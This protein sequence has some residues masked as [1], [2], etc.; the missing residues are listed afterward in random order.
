MQT[1]KKILSECSI[2]ST[3]TGS[4]PNQ[5]GPSSEAVEE[6]DN[7]NNDCN[8]SMSS[9]K[10][11]NTL[12]SLLCEESSDPAT[13]FK[14]FDVRL[15]IKSLELAFICKHCQNENTR[16]RMKHSGLEREGLVENLAINYKNISNRTPIISSYRLRGKGGGT[17]ELNVRSAVA[18]TIEN[19]ELER[20]CGIMGLQLPVSR[21]T[22]NE[23]FKKIRNVAVGTTYNVMIDAANR[24]R[25]I[26]EEEEP[27]K[28]YINEEGR[29]I[30]DIA[31]TVD[32]TW[33]KRGHTSRIG[34]VFVMAGKTGEVLD[35][36]EK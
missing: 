14:L 16:I 35:F 31:V 9:N 19:A 4:R 29:K 20:F 36:I 24:L 21:R 17:S 23:H 10:L 7:L 27:S 12:I 3:N 6:G 15:L 30:V 33:Q 28:V 25:D 2:A 32:G 8:V 11:A 13:G 1:A 34:V 18:S 22:Y 5:P 26:V